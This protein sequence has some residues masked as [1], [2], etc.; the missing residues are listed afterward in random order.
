MQSLKRYFVLPLLSICLLASL[1]TAWSLFSAE[2]LSVAWIGA[3][4]A[5]WPFLGFFVYVAKSGK[6]RTSRIMPLH[7]SCALLGSALALGDFQLLPLF[8]AGV[9]GLGGLLIYIFWYSDLGR[10]SNAQLRLGTQLPSFTLQSLQGEPVSSEN[11][12]GH[13]TLY[14]FYRGN[15]CP[16]CVAQIREVAEQY[17]ELAKLGVEVILISPQSQQHSQGLAARFDVP[18]QF[19]A[20]PDNSAAQTLGLMHEGGVPAGIQGYDKDTVYPTVIIT[21]ETGKII[22]LD[23]TDNYRVRPEPSVFIDAVS[24]H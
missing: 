16:L 9:V 19:Y 2:S 5:L 7:L 15:W 18:M 10:Q 14:L 1:H 12:K 8:Y 24:A 21:D 22:Y 6:G 13:K 4:L 3:A 20:D 17:R 23:L 11:F